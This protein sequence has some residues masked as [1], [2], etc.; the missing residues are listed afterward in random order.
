MIYFAIGSLLAMAVA[1]GFLMSTSDESNGTT[2]PSSAP[3]IKSAKKLGALKMPTLYRYTKDLSLLASRGEL[4]PVV[5]RDTEIRRVIQILSRRTKNNPILI[6]EAGVG[7]TAIVEGLAQ[8][9]L[10]NIWQE[11]LSSKRVLSLD[12]SSLLAGTKF[13]GEFEKRLK[14]VSNEIVAAERQIILFID[15]IHTLA[16]AGEA[17]GGIGAAD[18]LKPSLARGELQVV[19]AT[20]P[21]EFI[22]N[23]KHDSTLARRFQPVMINEPTQKQAIMILEALKPRYSAY[24]GVIITR[25]AI[26]K[27][28]QLS[29]RNIKG[30]RLPDKAIDVMDEAASL[31]KMNAVMDPTK[32][33]KPTVLPKD[34]ES[35][36]NDW[37][38]ATI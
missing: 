8:T 16:N 26:A 19:G 10:S 7:K 23:I 12:L 6:G 3:L 31:V 11:P 20:T 34:V 1:L 32:K 22:S 28:V 4:D 29:A 14:A 18:T 21:K 37:A 38:K 30:R 5:G 13:R 9:L 2:P 33:G 25:E 24:H 15:E 35:V 17:T 36:I 27:A